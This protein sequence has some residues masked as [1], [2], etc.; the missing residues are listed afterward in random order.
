MIKLFFSFIAWKILMTGRELV[1]NTGRLTLSRFDICAF[2]DLS[3]PTMGR[4]E[5]RSKDAQWITAARK[6]NS[7]PESLFLALKPSGLLMKQRIS[8]EEY[9][10]TLMRQAD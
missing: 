3:S 8:L 2:H 6:G 5:N 9:P 7:Y 4:K 1:I 10:M